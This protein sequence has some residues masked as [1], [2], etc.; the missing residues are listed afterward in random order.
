MRITALAILATIF[1]LANYVADGKEPIVVLSDDR[2]SVVIED[3]A[4]N[5]R[6]FN[7]AEICG[8]PA[9]G[10][11]EI[12]HFEVRASTIF[13]TFGKHCSAAISVGSGETQCLGCD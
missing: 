5:T 6:T 9:V 3:S 10:T 12:R 11:P 4:G 1:I 7:I 13:V 8:V 2:T